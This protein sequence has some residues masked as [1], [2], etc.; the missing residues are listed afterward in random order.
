MR[1]GDCIA[2]RETGRC[3]N[4][5]SEKAGSE[6]SKSDEPCNAA[7]FRGDGEC[8]RCGQP[9]DG[10]DLDV[11]EHDTLAFPRFTAR[12]CRRCSEELERWFLMM[13]PEPQGRLF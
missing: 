10:Y 6:V 2:F 8:Y 1:C 12:L 9:A 11:F 13:D 3:L 4:S 7:V 5:D